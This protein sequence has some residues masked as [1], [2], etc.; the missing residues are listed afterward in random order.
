MCDWKKSADFTAG[1]QKVREAE[2]CLN[3]ARDKLLAVRETRIQ[4]LTKRKEELNK[5]LNSLQD[6]IAECHDWFM[7]SCGEL[8]HLYEHVSHRIINFNSGR[9]T[10]LGTAST[11]TVSEK[12]VICGCVD[13]YRYTGID[14]PIK[15]VDK[16]KIDDEHKLLI[17]EFDEKISKINEKINHVKDELT[18]VQSD[19]KEICHIYGHEFKSNPQDP[20]HKICACCGLSVPYGNSNCVSIN[21]FLTTNIA[22]IHPILKG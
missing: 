20:T 21:E 11:Y 6:S 13:T 15:K 4:E 17:K 1:L 7:Y 18:A 9:H 3:L 2:S 8:G 5:Q 10:F 16:D 22:R 14:Y 12:C 19:F